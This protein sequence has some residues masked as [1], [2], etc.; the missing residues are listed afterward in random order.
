MQK[1]L[2]EEEIIIRPYTPADF[3]S[4]QDLYYAVF[5]KHITEEHF[6]WKHCQNPYHHEPIIFCAVNKTGELVAARAMFP[7]VMVWEGKE[8]PVVQAGDAMAREDYRGKGLFS[9]VITFG[10][11][12]LRER[13]YTMILAFPNKN[14]FHV[15]LQKQWRIVAKAERFTR[16]LNHENIL[17]HRA[18]LPGAGFLGRG[19]DKSQKLF[20]HEPSGYTSG[21]IT[22]D[23]G[24]ALEFIERI[25]RGK[26]HQKKDARYFH[27]KYMQKPGGEYLPVCIKKDG[28]ITALFVVRVSRHGFL[29]EGTIVESFI[30]SEKEAQSVVKMLVLHCRHAGLHVLHVINFNDPAT[31]RSFLGNFFLSRRIFLHFTV[32]VFDEGQAE[33]ILSRPWHVSLGDADTA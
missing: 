20:P 4:Y 31:K 30:S 5:H 1:T 2:D 21:A 32:R 27:W 19:L 17:A 8:Y 26:F 22:L 15:I 7:A 29:K 24:E 11:V 23:D 33:S 10:N 28:S 13:G 18:P 25:C 3:K 14:S 12:F 16:I 6:Q 9:R